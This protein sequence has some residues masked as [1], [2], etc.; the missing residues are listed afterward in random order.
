[1]KPFLNEDFL[2]RTATART[3]YHEYAQQMPIIGPAV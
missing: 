2:L 3:L 1:M